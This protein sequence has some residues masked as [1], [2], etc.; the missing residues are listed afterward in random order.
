MMREQEKGN[1]CIPLGLLKA[2]CRSKEILAGDMAK[3]QPEE[4][5][6]KG[7]LPAAEHRSA[8]ELL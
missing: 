3:V 2:L 8:R 6:G 4:W 1:G 5:H 7:P